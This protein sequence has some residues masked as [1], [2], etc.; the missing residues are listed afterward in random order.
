MT[1]TKN[2]IDI[3]AEIG[4][5][6]MGNMNLAKDMIKQAAMAGANIVKFQSYSKDTFQKSDPEYNWFQK[7]SLSDEDH[8]ML[9]KCAKDNNV[10][11]MSAP[12]DM[13]RAVF[14]CE[15]LGLSRLKVASGKMNDKNLLV[16]LN[17]HCKEVFLSTGMANLKEIKE[18][19]IYLKN[20][21]VN[22]LHCVSQYPL[23][24]KNANLNA[25][26]TL[27]KE[28]PNLNI[29]YSDHTDGIIAPIVA[30]VLGAV[31][32][33]KHFT[34]DK[35]FP[36]GTDHVLSATPKELKKIVD[37]IKEI[38][39]LLGDGVKEPRQCEVEII[40]FVRSRFVG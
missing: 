11:F 31:I 2:K 33:E 20:I 7:V 14:L 29:G 24:Y 18:S 16:Y 4:E 27:I 12:F 21:K 23:E 1:K 13:D 28:F 40:D 37:S 9:Q 39:E 26:K 32:I 38:S 19:L 35:N 17:S 5:N 36:E 10:E 34:L 8:F 15:T 22:I 30:V 6:H 3:I 25:I